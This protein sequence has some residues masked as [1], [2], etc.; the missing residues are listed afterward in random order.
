M[1]LFGFKEHDLLSSGVAKG[2]G[3][4]FLSKKVKSKKKKQRCKSAR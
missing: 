3:T 4:I 2:G 1:M